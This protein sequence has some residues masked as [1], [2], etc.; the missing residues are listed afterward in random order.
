VRV[1]PALDPSKYRHPCFGFTF[2]T[3][4]GN[5]FTFQAGEETLSHR[6]V[7][8]IAHGTHGGAYPQLPTP[9][10]KGYAGV[11]AALVGVMNDR[12]RLARMQCHVQRHDHQIR[13]HLHPKG[14]THYLAAEHV[15]DHRQLQEALP[16][17]YI[18]HIRHSELVYVLCHKLPPHQVRGRSLAFVAFG[19]HAPCAPAA[20]FLDVH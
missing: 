16:S 13:C 6:V 5:E 17:R 12:P 2:P 20:R 7:I 4:P 14:P 8:G 3:A 10:E 19:R 1:L 18:G 15:S 11:L 9:A